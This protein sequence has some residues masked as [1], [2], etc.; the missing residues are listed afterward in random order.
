MPDPQVRVEWKR[1]AIASVLMVGG[2]VFILVPATSLPGRSVIC[3]VMGASLIMLG[4]VWFWEAACAVRGS[5]K[6]KS[7]GTKADVSRKPDLP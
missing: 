4:T 5:R 1:V 3:I 7:E 6:Y 2:G